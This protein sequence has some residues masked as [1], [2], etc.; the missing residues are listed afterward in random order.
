MENKIKALS[1]IFQ[2]NNQLVNYVENELLEVVI[3]RGNLLDSLLNDIVFD[4]YGNENLDTESHP[5]V[6][7]KKVKELDHSLLSYR[8]QVFKLVYLFRTQEED[9]RI[10]FENFVNVK[11]KFDIKN[12]V[13]TYQ[14]TFDNSIYVKSILTFERVVTTPRHLFVDYVDNKL[15]TTDLILDRLVNWY[16]INL[17]AAMPIKEEVKEEIKEEVVPGQHPIETLPLP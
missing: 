14:F 2:A 3:Q 4:N 9:I 15:K 13:T 16:G 8:K 10:P 6:E 17:Y 1:L 12:K 11:I 5:Y 7:I